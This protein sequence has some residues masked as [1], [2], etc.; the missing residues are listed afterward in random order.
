MAAALFLSFMAGA[1]AAHFGT[2]KFQEL[3]GVVSGSGPGNE[4]DIER[5][6]GAARS[7]IVRNHMGRYV[8]STRCAWPEFPG[9]TV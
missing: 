3:L 9:K 2:T 8:V 4:Q 7:E 1:A 5:S 6:Q